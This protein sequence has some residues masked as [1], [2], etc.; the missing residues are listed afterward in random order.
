[1]DSAE[2]VNESTKCREDKLEI[3]ELKLK[4]VDLEKK[5]D[6]IL[7]ILKRHEDIPKTKTSTGKSDCI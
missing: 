2:N 1:M 5:L 6:E 3:L 7:N 4:Q